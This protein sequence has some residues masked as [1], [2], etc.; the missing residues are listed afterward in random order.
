M[1]IIA[2]TNLLSKGGNVY[3]VDEFFIHDYSPS[4]FI[5]DIALI[6]TA[7]EIEFSDKVQPIKL[8][9]S[10][11]HAHGDPAV[12]TGWGYTIDALGAMLS[13]DKLQEINLKIYEQSECQKILRNVYE[14]QI[15]ILTKEGEGACMGDSGGSLVADG[16]Q[17][18][19]ISN[20]VPCAR[21]YPDVYTRV[22]YYTEWI[23]EIIN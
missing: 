23:K 5:N 16:V 2:G 18:G 19:I 10:N 14:S 4:T 22:S 8:S 9:E 20:V 17:I 11:F 15:C 13:P 1:T 12:L 21:G 7:S 3:K 6:R